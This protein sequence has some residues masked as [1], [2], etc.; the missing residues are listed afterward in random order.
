MVKELEVVGLDYDEHVFEKIEE[1]IKDGR[2]YG[3]SF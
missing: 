1:T 2:G 3:I